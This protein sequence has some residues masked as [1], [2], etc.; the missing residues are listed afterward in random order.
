MTPFFTPREL[1]EQRRSALDLEYSTWRQHYVE[2]NE[3]LLP[4]QGRFLLHDVNRGIKKHNKVYDSTATRALRTLA[5]G[6]M[7]GMT[8]PARPW[9][10]Y[11]TRDDALMQNQNVKEWLFLLTRLTLDIFA[12]SNTY[13]TLHTMYGELG[14]YGTAAAVIL[15]N[16][17]NVI[18]HTSFACGE[19]RLS[20]NQL[21]VVDTVY[22]EFSMTVWQL[23]KEF[24]VDN[25]SA[26]VRNL[27]LGTNKQRDTWIPVIHVIEPRGERD[28]VS[29]QVKNMPWTNCY[30]E[31][32]A[33][34]QKLLRES[35]FRR[36][37]AIA[38]RWEVTGNDIYGSSPG[39]EVL[40]DAKQLQHQQLRKA[41][42]IDYMVKP[43]L[44]APVSSKG[45]DVNLLPGGVSWLNTSG[46]AAKALFEVRLDLSHL[47]ADIQDVRQRINQGF[48]TDLFRMLT[49]N[50]STQ[51][52]TA[53]EVAELHEEKLLMLGPVLERQENELLEPL[54]DTT[55]DY[56]VAA[57][58]LPVPPKELH[59]Q[60]LE[61]E[62]SG[63][64]A[65]AQRLIG[66]APIERVVGMI[67][68]LAG[69]KP[70]ALDKLD[71]DVMIDKVSDLLGA[72][73]E[74]IVANDKVALIR[75]QRAQQQQNMQ[76]LQAAQI[77][78]QTAKNAGQTDTGGK[79]AL[80]DIMAGLQGYST[81]GGAA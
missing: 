58:L 78:S 71:V 46:Q 59:G 2:I 37:V 9:M 55:F 62:F 79:N 11:R 25:L 61:I 81:G 75:Q 31:R 77:A 1:Y 34:E 24:G 8:S 39:M 3:N 38:P 10:R 22:R 74:I 41:Q 21:G 57:N 15:P 7:A 63:V 51:P 13:R 42:G 67:T 54:L 45:S 30:Y 76:A 72:D 29:K 17:E 16:F 56:I 20:T 32:D 27:Y 80:T 44:Q 70:E 68:S 36:F 64:L 33:N 43:P 53:R 6:L 19:Y 66:V 26:S 35:G 60:E 49:D 5:A 50:Q 65:Q 47:L 18:H 73:P 48:Y 23:V 4:R 40:G 52:I 12:A 28:A 14:G 69:A